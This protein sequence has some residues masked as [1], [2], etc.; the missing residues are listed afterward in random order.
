MLSIPQLKAL[1]AKAK[2]LGISFSELLR[3]IIDAYLGQ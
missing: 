1:K 2:A 3:R